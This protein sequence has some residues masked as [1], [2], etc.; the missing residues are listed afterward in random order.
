MPRS[1]QSRM[2]EKVS[3]PITSARSNWPAGE[4]VVGSRD[5]IDEAGADGLDV[6]RCAARDAEFVLHDRCGGGKGVVRRRGRHDDQVNIIRRQPRR[7]QRAT[8][9]LGRKIRC[10]LAVCRDVAL[11]DAGA[12]GDPLIVCIDHPARDLRWSAPSR[13]GIHR[14]REQ[15]IQTRSL[16]RVPSLA[17]NR[18]RR[19]LAI[20]ANRLRFSSISAG[21]GFR[22]CRPQPKSPARSLPRLCHHGFSPRRR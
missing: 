21:T 18:W 17:T 10:G 12:C 1:D 8:R 15:L 4:E 22:P 19:A 20:A 11:L 5:G 9:R 14:R 3:A 2:R 16:G 6:E 7:R 13:A